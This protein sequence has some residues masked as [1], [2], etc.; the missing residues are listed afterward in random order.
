[1]MH[2]NITLTHFMTEV[3]HLKHL[4]LFNSCKCKLVAY[5]LLLGGFFIMRINA[6]T[7]PT[8]DIDYNCLIKAAELI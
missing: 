5:T 3:H 7:T 8:N 6:K 1:M 2:M 4:Q